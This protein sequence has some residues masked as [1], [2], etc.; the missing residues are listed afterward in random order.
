MEDDLLMRLYKIDISIEGQSQVTYC[1]TRGNNLEAGSLVS[2]YIKNLIPGKD[3]LV[4]TITYVD[5]VLVHGE[6]IPV[7]EQVPIAQPV[8]ED[9]YILD[10]RTVQA[11]R[12]DIDP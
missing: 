5:Q 1:A 4:N 6:P 10:T 8:P 3:T 11:G 7:P 9:G 12:H 2:A